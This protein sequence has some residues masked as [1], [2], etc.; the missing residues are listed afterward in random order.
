MKKL[1]KTIIFG[2]I[3]VMIA[4]ISIYYIGLANYFSLENIKHNAVYLKRLVHDYYTTSVLIFLAISI[5]LVACTLPVTAPF[6]VTAGFLFGLFPGTI[7]AMI[8]AIVGPAFSFLIVRYT[9]SQ[10]FK[11]QYTA[12]LEKFNKKLHSYGHTYLITLQLLTVVPY[13]IINTLAALAGVPFSTFIWTTALGSFPIIVIYVF[14][15]RE[16]YMIQ[17]WK[18]I[19]SVHMLLLLF[20]LGI[21]ALLPMIV[22]KLRKET[23]EDDLV[24]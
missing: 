13:F 18:D 21:L 16:L 10:V 14:A 1:Q 11:H 9:M 3:C 17:S 20:L 15:G 22:R 5:F 23:D 24:Q 12:Q 7:Y 8:V 6:A 4:A 19:M 2:F